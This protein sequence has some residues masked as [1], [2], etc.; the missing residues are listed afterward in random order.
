MYANHVAIIKGNFLIL[1]H[2]MQSRLIAVYFCEFQQTFGHIYYDKGNKVVLIDSFNYSWQRCQN[3]H[4]APFQYTVLLT[5]IWIPIM[6]IRR[7]WNRL[8][9]RFIFMTRIHIGQMES[10]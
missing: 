9:N 3:V 1:S 10:V 8:W 4:W 7:L 2:T 6:R 5:G